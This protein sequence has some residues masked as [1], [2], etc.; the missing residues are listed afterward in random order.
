MNCPECNTWTFVLQT[1]QRKT[2]GAKT[3]RYECAN[4]HRFSTTE[5]VNKANTCK[6]QEQ[7]RG[8]E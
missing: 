3:R 5:Q 8:H 7:K 1:R 6:Q 4:G 2:D